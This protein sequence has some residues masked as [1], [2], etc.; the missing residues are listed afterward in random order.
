MADRHVGKRPFDPLTRHGGLFAVG[1]RVVGLGSMS[2]SAEGGIPFPPPSHRIDGCTPK[3]FPRFSWNDFFS[4]W[5]KQHT[6]LLAGGAGSNPAAGPIFPTFSLE[7]VCL[8]DSDTSRKRLE[9]LCW[10]GGS[11]LLPLP[12]CTGLRGLESL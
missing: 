12:R 9:A 10:L 1:K 7:G 8:V 6:C 3:I 11:G 2:D 5:C 4:A